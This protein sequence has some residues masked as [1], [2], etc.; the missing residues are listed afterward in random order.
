MPLRAEKLYRFN[1]QL[2]FGAF[3]INCYPLSYTQEAIKILSA[4]AIFSLLLTIPLL[5]P[6]VSPAF[7]QTPVATAEPTDLSH[8]L[9]AVRAKATARQTR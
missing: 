8:L 4:V 9:A 2:R 6:F 1:F 7:S 5:V 3:K